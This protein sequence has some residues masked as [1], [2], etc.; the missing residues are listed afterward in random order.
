[1][2]DRPAQ[3]SEARRWSSRCETEDHRETSLPLRR[4]AGHAVMTEASEASPAGGG[5]RAPSDTVAEDVMAQGRSECYKAR[6]AFYACCEALKGKVT[7]TELGRAGLLYPTQCK[8]VR[9]QYQRSCR[10][11]WVS[12]FDRIYGAKRKV[13]R[14]LESTSP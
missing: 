7:P 3:T 4:R 14:L 11:T 5:S 13:Q 6:D 8:G 1:M 10:S 2:P 9:E 12:H